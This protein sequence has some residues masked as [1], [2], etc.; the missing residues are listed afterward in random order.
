MSARGR[1]LY[2]QKGAAVRMLGAMVDTTERREQEEWHKLLVAELQHRV[3]NLIAMVRSVARLSASSHDDVE[4][5]VDHLIG[6]LQAMGRTQGTLT[7]SPGTSVDLAE[8]V[9]EE[10]LVH[11]AR[12]EQCV[13]E[14]PDV[15]LA[16]HAAEIVTLA[17]HELATNSI[18]YGALGDRGHIR[19]NWSTRQQGNETWV[20]LRW[21]ETAPHRK[22]GTE[23]KGFG[24][25]LIEERLPYELRGKGRLHVHDTGVLAE[26][27][28]PLAEGPSILETRTRRKGRK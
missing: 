4:D 21:Q 16:P 24:R 23:R 11:A 19:I 15:A 20:A 14:G 3:R 6:R 12:E 5:Y 17:V 28:F 22:S 1:F 8:L 26:L 2:D 25:R 18:K 9:R 7:R 27:E 13:V 10:L